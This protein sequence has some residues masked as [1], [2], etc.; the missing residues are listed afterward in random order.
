MK[1]SYFIIP[2]LISALFLPNTKSF[3]MDQELPLV[4]FSDL[5]RELIRMICLHADYAA[6]KSLTL[7][8]HENYKLILSELMYQ[9]ELYESLIRQD[10]PII[11]IFVKS[12]VINANTIVRGK[13]VEEYA[14]TEKR[15]YE[16]ITIDCPLHHDNRSINK[17]S[18]LPCPCRIMMYT[19]R[20]YN[21]NLFETLQNVHKIQ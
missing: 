19:E 8:N 12:R 17:S 21:E 16:R 10:I 13:R 18:C 1:Q 11:S 6:T 20:I 3:S 2:V 9:Q 5:P 4:S 15:V 7:T 14:I